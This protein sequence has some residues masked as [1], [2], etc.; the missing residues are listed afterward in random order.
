MVA[1]TVVLAAVIAAFV[2]GMAGNSIPQSTKIVAFNVQKVADTEISITNLGGMGVTDLT[3]ITI[4]LNDQDPIVLD[5]S[6]DLFNV[7]ATKTLTISDGVLKEER[8]HVVI[9]GAF[10]GNLQEQIFADTYV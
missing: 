4:R 6:S 1:I 5:D 2:F 3:K 8:N 7:G 10:G 9:T